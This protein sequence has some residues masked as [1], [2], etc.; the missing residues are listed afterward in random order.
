M[1]RQESKPNAVDFLLDACKGCKQ[2]EQAMRLGNWED[3]CGT[4]CKRKEAARWKQQEERY[5]IYQQAMAQ[6][7]VFTR[8]SEMEYKY[9]KE[10][11]QKQELLNKI[12]TKCK[13]EETRITEAQKARID[14][15]NKHFKDKIEEVNAS[16]RTKSDESNELYKETIETKEKEM[17]LQLEYAR[18][19]QKEVELV[20]K[21]RQ[22]AN[23]RHEQDKKEIIEEIEKLEQQKQEAQK[24]Y[25]TGIDTEFKEV[26]NEGF[27]QLQY[28]ED[29]LKRER[30]KA[31][32]EQR[33]YRREKN[34]AEYI[35][36]KLELEIK[37]LKNELA[38]AQAL[39]VEDREYR[40]EKRENINDYTAK[41]DSEKEAERQR[42]YKGRPKKGISITY[43]ETKNILRGIRYQ[44]KTRGKVAEEYGVTYYK[45]NKVL[46][47]DYTKERHKEQMREYIRKAQLELAL[48]YVKRTETED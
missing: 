36:G 33:R 20:E 9:T 40:E 29:K 10:I 18:E 42:E 6:G 34:K 47:N 38:K 25:D 5:N 22:E 48:E 44:N 12:I 31:E 3:V 17:A 24:E 13:E 46:N 2:V 11:K 30:E 26:I 45:I 35:K 19:V 14:K 16:L 1:N 37:T 41:K 23:E 27:Y 21:E 39:K 8:T 15:L 43:Q 28:A 32:V 4:N 7:Q